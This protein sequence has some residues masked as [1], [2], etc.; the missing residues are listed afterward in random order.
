VLT[1]LLVALGLSMDAFAVSVGSGVCIPDLTPR[2]ALRA[3]LAFGLFQFMMPV[4]G[5]L[6]GQTFRAYIEGLDHWIAFGLLAFIGGK[7]VAESFKH[8]DP[9]SC[10]DDER[11]K[12]NILDFGTLM[13]LSVATS[14][15]ALAVGISYS[16]IGEPILGPSAIIGAVTFAVCLVGCEFGKRIGARFERWA[17]LGG[18]V[19]LVGIGVKIAAEHLAKG[20]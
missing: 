14:I 1:Y 11:R 5:W 13:I 6:A 3:S 4:A 10:S 18:G 20:L 8:G 9:D 7:M 19:V 2:Y 16:M 12:T 15:D 17:E